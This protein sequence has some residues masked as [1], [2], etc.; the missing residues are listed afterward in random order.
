MVREGIGNMDVAIIVSKNSDLPL[1]RHHDTL[2][3][4]IR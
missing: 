3:N 2:G 4:V 1:M